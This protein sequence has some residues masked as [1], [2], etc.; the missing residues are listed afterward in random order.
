MSPATQR[1]KS[2][3]C[4]ARR[5][6][7]ENFD[8]ARRFFGDRVANLKPSSA[9]SLAPDTG[10]IA[11]LNG[12]RVAAYR[13]DHGELHGV[14]AT[15]THLGCQVTFNTAER[16]WDCPCHGSRFDIEGRV[17]QGPAVDDLAREE[18]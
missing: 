18:G 1:P 8:V 2:P 11:S 13:D 17:V 16:T 10:A 7:R 12:K 9:S 3:R 4:G 14:A 6:V 5:L 15:C